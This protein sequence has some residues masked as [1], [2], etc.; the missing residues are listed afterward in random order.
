MS[1]LSEGKELLKTFYQNKPRDKFKVMGT[2]VPFELH[3]VGVP[4]PVIGSMDLVLQDTA[5][6][7]I[8]VDHKTLSRSLTK[9]D[10]NN[11]LQLTI[12][13]MA[14]KQNGFTQNEILL[15]YDALIKTRVPKFEQYYTSRNQHDEIKAV[16]KIQH[17]WKAIEKEIFIPHDGT[18]KCNY[19]PFKSQCD[20]WFIE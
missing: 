14:A 11:S 18:W 7:I 15:R 17:V 5:G 13:Y 6:N 12:Y 1:I 9:E 8:I 2:E 19:C 3:L 10:V 16:K 4:V 20:N